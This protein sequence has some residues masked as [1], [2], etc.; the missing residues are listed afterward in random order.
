M[1]EFETVV[2][3]NSGLYFLDTTKL[4]RQKVYVK[5]G[6]V[7][8]CFRAIKTLVVRGAPA[9]GVAAAY[10]MVLA[11]DEARHD[12]MEHFYQD[13][14]MARD[15]LASSRPTAVNLFYAL[16]RIYEEVQKNMDKAVEEIKEIVIDTA[17]AIKDEDI[18]MCRRMGEHGATLLKDGMTVLTHCNA[19]MLAASKY[20]TALA[21]IYVAQERGVHINVYADETRPLLQGARLTA[22]ELQAHG[23]DVTLIC[24]NMA[25][26][27]MKTKGVDAVMVGCDR[28]AANGDFANKIGTYNLA[29]LAQYHKIPFYCIGPTSTI[30]LSIADGSHI[31]IEEREGEEIKTSFGTQ[32]APRDVKVFNPAFDV[33]PNALV[34][35]IIT[36]KGI[37]YP[38]FHLESLCD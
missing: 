32:C 34:T 2:Y 6:S 18:T 27:V 37:T 14:K 13:L 35:A 4:P 29:I 30:D 38:P 11:V 28:I 23:V 31:P 20:G 3:D 21:P 22:Y 16:D 12:S 17:N 1:N 36:E 19:G 24:D 25:A 33:T 10:A 15:Y 26:M 5:M 7:Q 9:I 8:D